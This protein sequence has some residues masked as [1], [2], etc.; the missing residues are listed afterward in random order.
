LAA[1]LAVNV[2]TVFRV[3]ERLAGDG[4]LEL[5]QGAGTFVASPGTA[6][7]AD[8]Q[9]DAR[10]EGFAR[11]FAALAQRGMMWGFTTQELK[12]LVAAAARDARRPASAETSE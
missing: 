12:Q 11:E 7:Q 2:N 10:R 9:R 3:Y 8:R 6:L 4:V 1:Q 5:R